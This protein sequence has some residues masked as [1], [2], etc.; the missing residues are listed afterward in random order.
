LWEPGEW[1]SPVIALVIIIAYAVGLEIL[2]YVTSTLLFLVAWQVFVERESW[3]KTAI[4]AFIGTAVMYAL[5]SFLLGV[6][7]PTGLLL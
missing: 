6:P 7:L 5:F 3:R 1:V 2:G 4:I